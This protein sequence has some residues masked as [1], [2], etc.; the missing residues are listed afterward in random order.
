MQLIPDTNSRAVELWVDGNDLPL[1]REGRAVRLQ[2]EGWPAVQLFGW[3]S[4][5][6]GT[7]GGRVS[8]VDPTDDERGRFRI[9]V[10][11]DAE[12]EP[13]PDSMILRQGTRVNGFVLLDQV[14]IGYELWRQLNG[15]PPTVAMQPERTGAVSAREGRG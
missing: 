3:P 13:W 8:L 12:I 1:I 15:F 6:V 10:V 2:V 5:A 4:V 7:F 14:S 11:P 9:L